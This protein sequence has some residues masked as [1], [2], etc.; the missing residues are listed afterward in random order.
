MLKFQEVFVEM[1]LPLLI[2]ARIPR[3]SAC[4]ATQPG[5]PGTVTLPPSGPGTGV[6]GVEMCPCPR[7]LYAKNLCPKPP[8]I[9]YD[10]A[11]EAVVYNVG[12]TCTAT[13]NCP[14]DYQVRFMLADGRTLNNG[15]SS[16]KLFLTVNFFQDQEK[17]ILKNVKCKNVTE[18]QHQRQFL[19]KILEPLR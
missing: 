18:R 10:K 14:D 9:C 2:L 6:P 13:L 11:D 19:S 16:K 15:E 7:N 12:Q 5:G 17:H 3:F 1:L 8:R 4:I